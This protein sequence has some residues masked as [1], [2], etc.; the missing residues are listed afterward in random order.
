MSIRS[1]LIAN[2][3]EIAARIARACRGLGLR[4]VAAY[5]D[6]DRDAPHLALAD[7]AVRIGG[8]AA[9]DSYLNVAAIVAAARATG[10]DAVHPGYGFLAENAC[11]AAACAEAGLTFVGPSPEVIARMG[12]KTAAKVAAEL[13]GVAVVPGYH[14]RDQDDSVLAVEAARIGFP[15]M[16][17]ASAGGGGRGIRRVDGVGAF[18]DALALARGEARAAF[19]DDTVLLE[20]CIERA[21]HVEVQI[22]A[23][24]HGNVVHLFDRDCSV[25]RANQKLVEE[26][27]APNLPAATRQAMLD[28]A[29]A[30]ARHIGYRNAGTVEFVYDVER[31]RAWFLEMNTRLQV[32][33][34]VT[35]AVT[36]IDLVEWQI[37]IADGEELGFR[38]DE[39]RCDGHA[40]EARIAAEDPAAGYRPQT[41]TIT[42]YLEPAGP[43]I[44]VDSGIAG[45][46]TVT[47]HYD[48][49][50]AKLIAHGADRETAR[51]RLRGALGGLRVDGIRTN[52]AFLA[53]V[54]DLDRFR[55]ASHTTALLAESFP[56][57][58]T[59]PTPGRRAVGEAV[60][61]H[62]LAQSSDGNG[63]APPWRSLGAWRVTEPAG[64]SGACHWL[65]VVDGAAPDEATLA[66]R[67]N[68]RRVEIG[69][70]TALDAT[71]LSWCDGVLSYQEAGRRH[72]VRLT[73]DG[74]RVWLPGGAEVVLTR[75]GRAPAD[76]DAA[77]GDNRI[78]APMPGKLVEVRIAV[79]DVVAAGQTVAVVEAMK[80]FQELKAPAAGTVAAVHRHAG[81]AVD[82]DTVLIEIEIPAQGADRGA[83]RGP[84]RRTA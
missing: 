60:L 69:G 44:R 10:A 75:P 66:G 42:G 62:A 77:A 73:V 13:A 28:Q 26:A 23:D 17:K 7:E 59:A 64:R 15:L 39:L 19:G 6:A 12:S 54:L 50:L 31:E 83:D 24:H 52:R 29:V 9:A 82:G 35:E 30:L 48:S 3:G 79:G 58:W 40:I 8:A 49:M 41:G 43:G 61:A 1:V 47:P 72:R 68:R 74:D 70:A 76:T 11:F 21:R 45:G 55:A 63:T 78:R 33:H 67:G 84:D 34:P 27:P 25:Q 22:L 4:A 46:S 37:R 38:Q 80:L 51:R 65:A 56:D 5:S 14:G 71:D 16:I 32:E 81:E 2:R 20:R 57:G 53:E 18:A 36:G